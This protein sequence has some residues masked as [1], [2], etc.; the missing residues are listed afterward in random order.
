MRGLTL[1]WAL[2]W[3]CSFS[4]APAGTFA[5]DDQHACPEGMA[6]GDDGLCAPYG[7]GG[8]AGA[9]AARTSACDTELT[10]TWDGI[11]GAPWPDAWQIDLEAGADVSIEDGAGQV[12]SDDVEGGGTASLSDA[13][14]MSIDAVVTVSISENAAGFSM[15]SHAAGGSF[16]GVRAEEG[17]GLALVRV[18]DG[19]AETIESAPDDIAVRQDPVRL[20]FA[21]S[22]AP[23]GGLH[24]GARLWDP[25]APEPEAWTL[26]RVDQTAAL[27]R[28]GGAL[29]GFLLFPGRSITLDDYRVCLD[30]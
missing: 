4:R 16:Y 28:P 18:V 21:V 10:E 7:D 23:G 15:L 9:D 25:A 5:C 22:P 2:S 14:G 24:L 11:D 29:L 20:R 12:D 26:E 27:E 17:V 6:C 8:G 30:D 1:L 3:G 19:E 13:T